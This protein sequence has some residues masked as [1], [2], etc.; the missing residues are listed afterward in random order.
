MTWSTLFTSRRAV[1]ISIIGLLLSMSVAVPITQA[2]QLMMEVR[3]D[4]ATFDLGLAVVAGTVTCSD[5]TNYTTLN[6]TV[7]QPVGR[8]ESLEGRVFEALGPCEDE[9]SFSVSVVPDSGRFTPGIVYIT[10]ETFACYGE[11]GIICDDD[12]V[13]DAVRLRPTSQN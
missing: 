8:F 2:Q 1:Y 10:A 11:F 3:I 7:R 13:T 4:E 12:S 9:L 6:V 5:P